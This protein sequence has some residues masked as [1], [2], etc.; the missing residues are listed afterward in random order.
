MCLILLPHITQNTHRQ[1]FLSGTSYLPHGQCVC[2]LTEAAYHGVCE[3][4]CSTSRHC[5]Y[6][7]HCS[8]WGLTLL[9][10]YAWLVLLHQPPV[11]SP[12]KLKHLPHIQSQS[13]V[14]VTQDIYIYIFFSQWNHVWILI[15]FVVFPL[16]LY[17]WLCLHSLTHWT[18]STV[19]LVS[20]RMA[21]IWQQLGLCPMQETP[22]I[23]TTNGA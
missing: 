13:S 8:L 16:P 18:C 2:N 10:L 23:E 15:S 9:K 14:H 11:S 12:P 3:D 7:P 1:H 22:P 20:L 21:P 6:I 17:S 19:R 5:H 4:S